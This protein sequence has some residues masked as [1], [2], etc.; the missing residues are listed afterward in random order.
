VENASAMRVRSVPGKKRRRI[1]LG[2]SRGAK[3][4]RRQEGQDR[5]HEA[6]ALSPT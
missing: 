4:C 1:I 2:R 3:A 5:H 6:C